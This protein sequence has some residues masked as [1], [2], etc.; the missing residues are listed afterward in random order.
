MKLSEAIENFIQDRYLQAFTPKT[1]QNYREV[2]SALLHFA[3]DIEAEKLT[4]DTVRK[5]Q[6]RLI[7]RGLSKATVGTYMRHIKAFTNWMEKE[8][9]IPY[10]SVATKIKPP[11]T[12]KKNL[13]LLTSNDLNKMF[14]SIS[15]ESEWLC[16]RDRLII[17]LMYDSG[18]RQNEVCKIMYTDIDFDNKR[19]NI[20]GK[21][22]KD[23]FVPFGKFTLHAL[24]EYISLCPYN[25]DYLMCRRRGEQLNNDTIKKMIS[26]LKKRTGI[27]DLS[28]HKLRHNFATNY[29]IDGY[30][31]EGYVDNEKL[32]IIMGHES[33]TTTEKYKHEALEIVSSSRFRS[34]LDTIGWAP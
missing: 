1:I 14:G 30:M 22:N 17:A 29:C 7:D 10:R 6:K 9:I 16:S 23:R 13:N 11:K 15:E 32:K 33:L 31:N 26:K 8:S 27:K 4:I 12:P 25:Y 28:S 21:G 2:L 19:I 24:N 5:Y 20:H 34:H 3:G 18:L